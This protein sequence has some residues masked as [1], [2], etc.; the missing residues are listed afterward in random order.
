[1]NNHHRVIYILLWAGIVS[2]Y[3]SNETDI[4]T[5]VNIEDDIIVNTST[6]YFSDKIHQRE[7]GVHNESDIIYMVVDNLF[8]PSLRVYDGEE[9]SIVIPIDMPI[10]LYCAVCINREALSIINIHDYKIYIEE[11]KKVKSY[12]NH[13]TINTDKHM[14]LVELFVILSGIQPDKSYR[15][16][17]KIQNTFTNEVKYM[18]TYINSNNNV[19]YIYNDL[20]QV[21][22][23]VNGLACKKY[24]K[25]NVVNDKRY[26]YFW[27]RLVEVKESCQQIITNDNY[28]KEKISDKFAT[29]AKY[30][31]LPIIEN[32]LYLSNVNQVLT[33]N[34][35]DYAFSDKIICIRYSYFI[36]SKKKNVV[37]ATVWY[38]DNNTPN[39]ISVPIQANSS[40]VYPLMRFPI[41]KPT[42][43]KNELDEFNIDTNTNTNID[44]NTYIDIL[45]VIGYC[46]TVILCIIIFVCL[47]IHAD[48]LYFCAMRQRRSERYSDY[49]QEF[50]PIRRQISKREII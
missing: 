38:L 42:G 1:M 15:L 7:I 4:D 10:S 46:V 16:L 37:R 5:D 27:G 17:C 29:S 31:I 22:K 30:K 47:I 3:G 34:I 25:E 13:L 32:G 36:N 2:I 9:G 41:K 19:R 43:W 35:D 44:T 11:L 50:E 21:Q 40:C 48:S 45:T 49:R 24:G 28:P 6:D 26:I 8:D 12:T 33:T 20:F 18:Q 14:C 23:G 39:I